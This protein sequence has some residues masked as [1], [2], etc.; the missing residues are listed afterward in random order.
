VCTARGIFRKDRV[1]P[2]PGDNVE[3][4]IDV[5]QEL[6]GNI[7]NIKN[8]VSALHRPQVANAQQLLIVLTLSAPPPDFLL[9]D[10]M[11]VNAAVNRMQSIICVNKCD[12]D[13]SA[14]FERE[15][16]GYGQA[17][18]KVIHTSIGDKSGYDGLLAELDDRITIFAGQSGVGKSTIFNAVIDRDY[19]KV[20]NMSRKIKRGKHT[21]RHVEL[22][23]L[24]NGG[25][26]TDTPGFSV[27]DFLIKEYRSLDR[28]YPEFAPYI[29]ECR[30]KEC[31]HIHEPLCKVMEAVENGALHRGRY[32]RYTQLYGLYKD[33]HD[34][35]YT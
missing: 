29:G 18:Y 24:R 9:A 12:L 34:K 23:A 35:K 10:K 6:I 7:I 19:M 16:E 3:F 27:F 17:G 1:T 11:L 13:G 14:E 5:S 33:A 26:I 2:L 30:F 32:S 20:G 21:T 4:E 28:Y 25:Y 31:S 15:I 22:V 8:R